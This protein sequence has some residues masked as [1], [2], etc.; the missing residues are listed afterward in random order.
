MSE[1]LILGGASLLGGL[2]ANW[3]NARMAREQM[4]FQERMVG[5]QEQFQERMANTAVQRQ[6]ADLRA[7][8]VNPML[9]VM[10]GTPG[11]ATPSGSAAQGARAE[12]RDAVGPAVASALMARRQKAEIGLIEAQTK[13]TEISGS[14][15][16]R[17]RIDIE[18]TGEGPGASI[19]PAERLRREQISKLIEQVVEQSRAVASGRQLT[20][21]QREL[22][23]LEKPGAANRA[24]F[25][26]D[27]MRRLGVDAPTAQRLVRTLIEVL[28]MRW[29]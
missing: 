10:R 11:A 24:A 9:A 3:A 22:A 16:Q 20:D 17:Q 4:A 5:R 15:T 19:S 23:E 28:R 12:M 6:M 21:V 14:L 29:R 2:G 8:N 26:R 25:E 13:A 7:A 18:G 27:L 1:P